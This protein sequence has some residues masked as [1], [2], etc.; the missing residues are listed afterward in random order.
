MGIFNKLKNLLEQEKVTEIEKMEFKRCDNFGGKYI[1]NFADKSFPI[2]PFCKSN[3]AWEIHIANISVELFPLEKVK[4]LYHMR[5]Q[6]CSAIIH[7]ENLRNPG[8]DIPEFILNPNPK[9][10][11]KNVIVDY[12][13]N[14]NKVADITGKEL[15][16]KELNEI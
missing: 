13:G 15:T 2:C 3:P 10:C 6:N 12:C 14:Q 11:A 9:S 5:C 1:Q 7:V 4:S 16:I 8:T